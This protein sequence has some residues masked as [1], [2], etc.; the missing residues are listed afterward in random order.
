MLRVSVSMDSFPCRGGVCPPALRMVIT[1]SFGRPKEKGNKKKSRLKTKAGIGRFFGVVLRFPMVFG[2]ADPA[3]TFYVLP[4]FGMKIKVG[5][6]ISIYFAA[7]IET[8][9]KYFQK[10]IANPVNTCKEFCG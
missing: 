5:I 6:F 7:H 4:S 8:V 2:R 1:F 9:L 3:P 10:S